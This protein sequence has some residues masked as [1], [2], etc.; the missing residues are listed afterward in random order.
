MRSLI[1]RLW[2]LAYFA[3]VLVPLGLALGSDRPAGANAAYEVSLATGLVA[4]SLLAVTYVLPTRVRALSR[5]LGIDVVMG[6]HRLVGVSA[7]TFV[8]V[9]VVSTV[10]IRSANLGL[11]DPRTAPPRARAGLGATVAMVLMVLL[12]LLGRRLR[13]R[14]EAWRGLHAVLA[15]AVI[16]LSALHVL[17]QEHLVREPLFA[18]WFVFL[19]AVV[20]FVSLRRWV[21]RPLRAL[22]HPYLVREVR[23]ESPT[24]TTVV[25]EPWGHRG[26]LRFQPGQFAW[27]RVGSTPFGFEEHPF[28]IANPPRRTGELEFTVKD[29]GDF[30]ASLGSAEVGDRVWVDGPHGAFTPQAGAERGLVLVAGGVGITPMMSTLRALASAG[31]EREHL[32]IVAAPSPEELLFREEIAAMTQRIPLT[33]V[34]VITRPSPGWSGATGRIDTELLDRHLPQ[35]M[36]GV[37]VYVCGP[38]AMARDIRASVAELGLDPGC[39]HDE[40]FDFA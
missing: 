33:V 2:A 14:F 34:E 29:L 38:P 13:G 3:V 21:W 16:V 10:M 25:L 1:R 23:R 26:L 9:H 40:S 27:V 7:L 12:A 31:D 15:V 35:D 8:L 30:T 6:V 37:E 19:L 5:G 22:I 11:L 39:V 18:K 36:E 24:V 20:G 32:L 4:L 17:W 28:T